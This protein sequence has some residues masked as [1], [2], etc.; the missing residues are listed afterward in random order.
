MNVPP[1]QRL[2]LIY[3]KDD[4]LMYIGHQ[5]L[6]R[7]I[8]RML[9][10]AEIPF[11]TS[12]KFSPKP[13]VSFGPA[14]PLG[15]TAAREPVDIE[16]A[17]GTHWDAAEVDSAAAKLAEVAAPRDFMVALDALTPEMP[18]L[19]KQVAQARYE[20]E[21][22]GE[23]SRLETLPS[24]FDGPLITEHRGKPRDFKPAILRYKL[25]G[26]AL[27]LDAHAGSAQNLNIVQLARLLSASCGVRCVSMHRACL[28]TNAG[29]RL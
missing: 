2:R 29:E 10:R 12:G 4:V 9:K 15:V 14:L 18:T 16:L 20:L 26:S 19:S 7:F 21:F 11:A 6:L 3:R 27:E 13:R 24:A 22:A 17:E 28:L 8:F 5:D 23:A 25:Q 1:R